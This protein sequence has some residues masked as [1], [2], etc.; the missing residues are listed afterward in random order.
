LVSQLEHAVGAQYRSMAR[1]NMGPISLN[2]DL[3]STLDY[4]EKCKYGSRLVVTQN[5]LIY[6]MFYSHI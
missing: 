3:F 6:N 2:E 5:Y 4:V 1:Y